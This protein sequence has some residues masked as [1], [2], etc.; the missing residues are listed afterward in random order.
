[1]TH[2]PPKLVRL[3]AILHE[4]LV[5]APSPTARSQAFDTALSDLGG[6]HRTEPKPPKPNGLEADADPKLAQEILHISE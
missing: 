5:Q 6:E 3:A 1:M 4:D 2:S